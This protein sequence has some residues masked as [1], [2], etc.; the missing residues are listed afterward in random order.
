MLEGANQR[1]AVADVSAEL[2]A[3]ALQSIARGSAWTITAR[4][5]VRAIGLVSTI[6]LARLLRPADF[7]IVA[8]A[9]IAVGFISVFSE[10]GQNLAVIRHPDPTAEHFDT[11]WTMSVCAGF[12]V[13]LVLVAVAPLAGWYYHEPRVVPVIRFLA[14]APLAGGFT[15]VGA[16]AG[17][18][19]SLQFNKDFGFT[20]IRKLSGFVVTVPLAL[21]W[22]SYW[23]LAAG[24]VCGTVLTVIA[25]YRLH[26]HRPRFCLTKLREIWSFSAWT[27]IAGI[28]SFFGDQT[29]QIVVGGLAGTASMGIYNIAAD[30][31]TAPTEELVT[32]AGRA[33]FP[34]YATLLNDPARLAE[35]YLSVLSLSVIVALATGVGVALVADDMV[36]L[37]LG[38]RWALA[39]PLVPWLAI[40]GAMLGVARSVNAVLSV[41]GNARLNAMRNWAFAALLAPAAVVGSLAWG[42]EG[43]AAARMIVTILFVP[44]MFYSLT[45]VIPVGGAEILKCLWRPA[46]ATAMMAAAVLFAGPNTMSPMPLRLFSNVGLGAVVFIA[47][48]LALWFVAGRPTG[49]ERM[50]IEQLRRITRR[51]ASAKL[52]RRFRDAVADPETSPAQASLGGPSLRVALRQRHPVVCLLLPTSLRTEYQPIRRGSLARLRNRLRQQFD[53]LR[54]F[55]GLEVKFFYSD[56]EERRNTNRGDISI[57]LAS[58]ELVEQAFACEVQFIEIAWEEVPEYDADWIN[59]RVD[60]FVI[61]GGGYYFL[62]EDGKLTPRVERDLAL[63]KRLSCPVVSL[64]PGVNRLIISDW[65]L[66]EVYPDDLPVLTEFLDQLSL[67]SIRAESGREILEHA[68]PGKTVRL[69][70]LALFLL[71]KVPANLAPRQQNG[72]LRVGLNVAFH[73]PNTG[74]TML[75]RLRVIATAAR[76]LA[77]RQPCE[78][79]Y[80]VHYDAERLIPR[81]LR[82]LG[83]PVRVVDAPPQEMLAWYSQLDLN[84]CQMLHSSIF[85]LNVGVP[86][87]NVSYDVKNSSFFRVMALDDYCLPGYSTD[88]ARLIATIEMVMARRAEL[89]RQI[90]ARKA[91]LRQEVNQFLS[92]ITSVTLGAPDRPTELPDVDFSARNLS[93]KCFNGSI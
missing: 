27:Q 38:P 13:A 17:F 31:A 30:I 72:T 1:A 52:R 70:D 29:D 8:M 86:T 92:A 62:E 78:F 60:L 7:G 44:V 74:S 22:Q 43:V 15:N 33:T 46:L 11:A 18:R 81:L 77:S 24:I 36:A 83:V 5:S 47:S 32:P 20:V 91:E 66:P 63:L 61:A 75:D 89:K 73:G 59:D 21:I 41:T 16:I 23:A 37:V 45:R 56:W 57:R 82:H 80:F 14:L 53:L 49:A 69:V 9:M 35:S 19:R 85:S 79:F 4:W 58:R 84:I 26:P 48:L 68:C 88:A 25:S 54:W 12:I 3:T 10:A 40:G 64:C 71:P 39:A 34:V 6:I 28:G 2:P 55:C 67:S 87:I 51:L 42:M 90:A 93:R 50:L 65:G 76:D